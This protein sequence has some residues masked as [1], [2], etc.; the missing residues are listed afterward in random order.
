MLR[1]KTLLELGEGQ[2]PDDFLVDS[3]EQGADPPEQRVL[4]TVQ[5]SDFHSWNRRLW[6]QDPTKGSRRY[7]DD[8]GE[9]SEEEEDD[10]G[11]VESASGGGGGS[12]EDG[13]GGRGNDGNRYD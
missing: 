10:A 9:T 1:G 12:P 5:Q 6:E 3:P 11:S 8:E 2:V 13:G 4:P 7:S